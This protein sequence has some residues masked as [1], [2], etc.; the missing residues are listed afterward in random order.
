MT[1]SSNFGGGNGMFGITLT[2]DATIEGDFNTI[3]EVKTTKFSVLNNNGGPSQ[4][5]TNYYGQD[6]VYRKGS[7]FDTA[8]QFGSNP[9]EQQFFHCWF[10]GADSLDDASATS[11]VITISYVVNMWELKGLGQS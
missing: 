9:G 1:P 6:K 5:V 11:F 2:D 3:R 7:N 10:E 8:A 4:T